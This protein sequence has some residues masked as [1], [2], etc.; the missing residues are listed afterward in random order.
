M[1]MP[2]KTKYR[3]QMR[4]KNR[5]ISTRGYELNF[6]E[7]GLKA[8]DSGYLTS[9]QIE[10]ARRAI[11]GTTKR[12]GKVYIRVFPDRPV[13]KKPLEVRMGKGKGAVDQYTARVKRGKMLFEL[14]GV[15][16][17]VAKEAFRIAA[18]KLPMKTVFIN[19]EEQL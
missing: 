7:F 1:L 6:G 2:K 13:T 5:G 10:A 17:S 14:A 19:G 12:G 8:V 9:R 16:M 11:T 15:E 4:G 18:A 3:K